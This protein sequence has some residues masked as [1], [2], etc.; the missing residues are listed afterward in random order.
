MLLPAAVR[1]YPAKT[2]GIPLKFEYEVTRG[3]FVYEWAEPVTSPPADVARAT[4]KLSH[5]PLTGHPPLA[6]RETEIFVPSA[7]SRGRKLIVSGLQDGDAY[8]HDEA[9]QTLFVVVAPGQTTHKITV[10]FDPPPMPMFSVNGFWGDF[11]PYV[12]AV[13]VIVLSALALA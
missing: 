10:E 11:G 12:F 7:L 13:I 9:R 1:P 8:T 3:R 4:N 6:S 2:A 5:V